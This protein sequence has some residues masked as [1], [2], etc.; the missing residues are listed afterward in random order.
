I[1]NTPIWFQRVAVRVMNAV[2]RNP[3]S[4]PAQLQMLIDGLYGNPEPA[5]ADLDIEPKPLTPIAISAWAPAIPSLFGFSLRL[6]SDDEQKSWLKQNES[7][8]GQMLVFVTF[9]ITFLNALTLMIPNAWYR[10]TLYYL[11]L[12]PASIYS[13]PLGWRRLIIPSV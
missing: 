11:A 7:S 4:T 13:V 1:V 6:V 10:M 3:L 5:K 9:A 2:S 8:L 12:I